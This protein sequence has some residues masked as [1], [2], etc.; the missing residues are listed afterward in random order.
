VSLIGSY[1]WVGNFRRWS[2]NERILPVKLPSQV[3]PR[4]NTS[5]RMERASQGGKT[6]RNE[7]QLFPRS[8][9]WQNTTIPGNASQ[10]DRRSVD[11][12]APWRSNQDRHSI[13]NLFSPKLARDGASGRYRKDRIVFAQ[14]DPAD[15]VFYIQDHSDAR[16]RALMIG[17]CP[18]ETPR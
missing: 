2:V 15:A 14:G 7:P 18:R 3:S 13:R 10:Q 6:H 9:L 16:A 1:P 8:I 12:V 11:D 4:R 5:G 17:S